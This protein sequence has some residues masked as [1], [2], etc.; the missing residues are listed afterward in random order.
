MTPETYAQ[1]TNLCQALPVFPLPTVVLMPNTLLPL[2]IFEHRY[3]DLLKYAFEHESVFGIA[4]L[5]PGYEMDYLGAP[6]VHPEIGIG[7][8]VAHETLEDGRSNLILKSIGRAIIEEELPVAHSFRC[9]RCELLDNPATTPTPKSSTDLRDLLMHIGT[10]R[11]DQGTEIERLLH[12]PEQ[13]LADELASQLLES[14]DE[15]REYLSMEGPVRIGHMQST[16]SDWIF[17]HGD[18]LQA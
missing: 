6:E 2:H 11:P 14:V 1:L 13:L 12:L 16:L 5:K 7:R 9:F 4:T 15:R 8:I 3:R 18:K 10:L 17:Q